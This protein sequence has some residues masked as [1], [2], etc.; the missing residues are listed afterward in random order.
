MPSRRSGSVRES[1][2]E[3]RERSVRNLGGPGVVGRPF[4]RSENGQNV[5]PE[6]REWSGGPPEVREWSGVLS[7]GPGVVCT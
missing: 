1:L 7:A 4:R 6:V 3:V 5:I 2:P